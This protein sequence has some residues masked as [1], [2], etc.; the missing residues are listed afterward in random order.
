MGIDHRQLM[1]QKPRCHSPSTPL[2]QAL[3]RRGTRQ[4]RVAMSTGPFHAGIALSPP[5]TLLPLDVLG[6]SVIHRRSPMIIKS[7]DRKALF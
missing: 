3:P 7:P 6:V 4:A 2:S 5:K 1:K